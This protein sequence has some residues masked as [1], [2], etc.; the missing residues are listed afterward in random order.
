[1]ETILI[2]LGACLMI[3]GIIGAFLPVIPGTPLSYLG[4]I[5]LQLTS[6]PPFSLAFMIIWAIIVITVTSLD[7]LASVVG[8]QRMGGTRY[9]ILGCM[10][11][12]VIGFFMFPPLGIIIGSIFGAFAGELLAGKKA[13]LAMKAAWGAI[14]GFFV[15]TFIKVLVSLILAYYFLVNVI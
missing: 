11:G 10:I 12:A 6:T 4:L 1:M 3:A 14:L 13:D 7:G 9:G 15:S 5:C 2:T 8:A